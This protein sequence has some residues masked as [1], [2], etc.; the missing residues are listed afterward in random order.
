[1]DYKIISK[2]QKLLALSESN[3]EHEAYASM[4]KAQELL[5]KHKLTMNEVKGFK[6]YNSAIKDF[7]TNISFTKGK[8]K[9]Q[10]ARLI[11]DNF[12]CYHFF[13]TRRTNTIIFFGREEDAY[14]CRILLE[15]AVDCINTTVRKLRYEYLKNGY[16]TKG[17]ENDYA[18]GFISGL[19]M[20]FDEQKATNEELALVLIKDK[21]VVEKYS[22][23]KFNKSIDTS[24]EREGYDDIYD[25]GMEDGYDFDI[26]NKITRKAEDETPN[27]IENNEIN[28][29]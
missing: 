3:N 28:I 1:M 26:S 20:K 11:A 13:N 21:M 6:V 18:L 15:Y 14:I 8:W 19:K 9:A 5:A 12:G 16:S 22:E 25:K 2:I 7:W 4:V 24:V 27:L 23:K 10:L 29:I 17:L